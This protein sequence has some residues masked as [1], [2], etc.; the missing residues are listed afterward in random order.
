MRT[1][2]LEC[3]EYGFALVDDTGEQIENVSNINFNYDWPGGL[4]ATITIANIH[5]KKGNPE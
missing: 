1:L 3:T 5:I 2:S 4:T